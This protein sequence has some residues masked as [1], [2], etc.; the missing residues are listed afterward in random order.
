VYD[1]KSW[2]GSIDPHI[3]VTFDKATPK[4]VE[5]Q[6][7][8][9]VSLIIFEWKDRHLIG[10][11]KSNESP[12]PSSQLE[13]ENICDSHNVEQK[14]CDTR[15]IGAFILEPNAHNASVYPIVSLAVHLSDPKEIRYPVTKTGFYCVSSFGYSAEEYTGE[16][17]FQNS[18]GELPGPQIPKLP[19][20]G[21]MTL[22]YALMAVYW[23]WLYVQNRHDILPVQNYI[24][25]IIVFLIVEQLLTWGFYDFQNRHGMTIGTK[26]LMFVVAVLNAGRNSFSF[27]LL[28][29]VCLG[30]GV[31]KPSLGRTMFYVR[32]LAIGHF[33]FGVIYAITSLSVPPETAGPWVLLIVLPLAATLTAFYV[34]TLNAM[35]ATMKDLAERKQR[36][37]ALM[38]RKLWWCMLGSIIVICGFFFVNSLI[39]AGDP[40]ADVVPNHWKSRWFVL[41]GWLNVV[42]L[43]DMAFVAY[44]WRPTVNNRRFAMSDEIAQDDEGF[45][46]R[47]MGSSFD[48][49]E[50]G[51]AA[52]GAG[53]DYRHPDYPGS[54]SLDPTLPQARANQPRTSRTGNAG[55]AGAGAG[56][57]AT[58]TRHRPSLDGETT[59]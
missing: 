45:E 34:W 41:D 43:C 52:G 47:S 21:V 27:F 31:V 44:L 23:G 56:A 15:D 51:R 12:P 20:Y 6:Q 36:V 37:K 50:D 24:T 16:V 29:I 48:D 40:V 33:V 22:V 42:Y 4:A 57:G 26:V 13:K 30:Y 8:P 9:L 28:L 39:F 38:Y 32:L 14:L 3:S 58:V 35:G 18:Y 1:K 55:P 54:A 17:N 49:E 25:A 19:F 2:W 7:D 11:I 59:Y 53:A 5:G 46:I 10:S